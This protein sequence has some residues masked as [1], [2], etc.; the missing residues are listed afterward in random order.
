MGKL[1][2]AGT[3]SRVRS[4]RRSNGLQGSRFR[5]ASRKSKNHRT[6]ADQ[7]SPREVRLRLLEKM[8]R[9]SFLMAGQF[10]PPGFSRGRHQTTRGQSLSGHLASL[11]EDQYLVDTAL[12][13]SF[14]RSES[15]AA[16]YVFAGLSGSLWSSVDRFSLTFSGDLPA[17][18]AR[19]T[20]MGDLNQSVVMSMS[21]I[22]GSS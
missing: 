6:R 22:C 20:A 3:I 18:G 7:S 10:V 11:I 2:N 5:K 12:A 13:R 8:I 9:A 19:R 16:R 21:N 14:F 1:A 4:G 15:E 17:G